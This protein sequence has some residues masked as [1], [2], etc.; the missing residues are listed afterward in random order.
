MILVIVTCFIISSFFEN[1]SFLFVKIGICF[2]WNLFPNFFRFL[3]FDGQAKIIEYRDFKSYNYHGEKYDVSQISL[4]SKTAPNGC[5]CE[6]NIFSDAQ[7]FHT[8][9]LYTFYDDLNESFV[10]FP[11]VTCGGFDDLVAGDTVYYKI[12]GNAEKAI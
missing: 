6:S 1:F 7:R 10:K 4:Q 11:S 9:H 12:F 8:P 2:G 3:H 5:I